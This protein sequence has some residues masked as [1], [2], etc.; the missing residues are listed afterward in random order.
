MIGE[1]SLLTTVLEVATECKIAPSNV[2]VFDAV[3]HACYADH[4]R[5]WTALLSHGEA[6]WVQFHEPD[7]GK[8]SIATLAFT[9]GTTGLPKAAMIAHAYHVSQIWAVQSRAKPYQVLRLLC[10]PA[11]HTFG[12][13]LISGCA[14][15]EG[16]PVYLMRRFEV[17]RFVE[18]ISRFAI[19]ETAVVPAMILAI[20]TYCTG[21]VGRHNL[22]SLRYVWSAGSPL[23]HSTQS[24]FQSALSPD[25]K[26][27]QVWGMTELGW[28]TALFWPEGDE[29][30]SVGRALPGMQIK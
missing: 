23:R 14:L 22:D 12:L 20:N 16:H 9:S 25:A 17:R 4:L 27:V 3:D 1:P 21:P 28:A 26:V 13:P 8:D 2:F 5:S 18:S 11:F 19:T 30:G 15:R 29:T 10:L 7:I 24:E 6:D